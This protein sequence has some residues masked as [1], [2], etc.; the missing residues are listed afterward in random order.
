MPL[1]LYVVDAFTTRP[2]AGNPAAVV[3]LAEDSA[4]ETA[5][6]QAVASEMR[7]SETAF[8]Q[9]MPSA[10][11]VFS[12]RWF[13]PAAEVQLCG[14]ATLATSHALWSSGS[15]DHSEP[16]VF[17]TLSGRLTCVRAADGAVRMDFPATPPEESRLPDG[18]L[19]AM[20]LDGVLSTW[21]SRFDYL[22]ELPDRAAVLGVKPDFRA[23]YAT[24]ARGI[25]VTSRDD[26][27]GV[28]FVSR[29]FAPGVGV[30]EDPVTG[31]AHCAL[32]PFWAKRLGKTRLA[33][34]QLSE[35]GGE[36]TVELHGD[37][38]VLEGHAITVT[39]GELMA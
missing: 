16:L 10:H 15:I 20:G 38:V 32:T 3:V 1:P 29:F 27:G 34:A 39:V 5:W 31:S 8:V 13:T 22:L 21:R 18:L 2:F 35:R 26:D 19:S 24:A 37:R 17:E 25:V 36:L 23:L 11:P 33:A 14:H 9:P 4:P 6:M 12:L 28:D 7:H 30:D